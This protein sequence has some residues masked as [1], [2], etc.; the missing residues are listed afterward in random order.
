MSRTNINLDDGL[1]SKGLKIT[2][3]RTKRE[4]VD[5]ALRELV[6]KEDQKSILT[7]EG[8]FSWNGDL[9]EI[10]KGRFDR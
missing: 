7:L 1:V 10:R 5:L 2:G 8:K 4:L 6:R 3:L 9:D